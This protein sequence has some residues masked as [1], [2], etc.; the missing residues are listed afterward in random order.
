VAG[1]HTDVSQQLG[2]ILVPPVYRRES[3]TKRG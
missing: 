3:I 1:E 2:E